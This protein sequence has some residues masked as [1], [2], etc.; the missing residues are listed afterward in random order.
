M[1]EAAER[2][3]HWVAGQGEQNAE[4]IFTAVAGGVNLEG[5]KKEQLEDMENAPPSVRA[6]VLGKGDAST[7]RDA[8]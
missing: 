2:N 7:E 3:N 8:G 6:A 1:Q 5:G 4:L